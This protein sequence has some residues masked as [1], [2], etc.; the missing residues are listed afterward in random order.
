MF[1]HRIGNQ[2]AMPLANLIETLE[3]FDTI[4]SAFVSAYHLAVDTFFLM[5]GLL[6]TQSLLRAFDTS[7][8]N[9]FRVVYRRYIRYTPVWAAIVLYTITLM[10]FT[11]KVDARNYFGLH[12][13]SEQKQEN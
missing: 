2:S 10:K 7:T 13:I 4:P 6:V 1:G 8:F 9:Y 11:T 12:F 5:G 3:F